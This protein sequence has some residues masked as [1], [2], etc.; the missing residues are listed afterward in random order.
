MKSAEFRF[1]AIK[2]GK[3]AITLCK[4]P[5]RELKLCAEASVTTITEGETYDAALIRLSMRDQ[6]GNVLPFFNE[7]IFFEIEGP[8]GLIGP[9]VVSLKGGMGG[10]YVKTLPGSSREASLTIRSLQAE[11][12]TGRFTVRDEREPL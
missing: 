6:Y 3:V 1:E 11:P 2:D 5:F 4:G 9:S 12:V 8:V 7:P 10:T